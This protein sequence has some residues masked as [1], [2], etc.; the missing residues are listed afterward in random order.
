MKKVIFCLA[1]MECAILNLLEQGETLLVLQ[2]GIWSHRAA[3]FGRRHGLN[4]QRVLVLSGLS[5]LAQL[6]RF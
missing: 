4:V 3:E 6:F 2:N 5:Y 1:G